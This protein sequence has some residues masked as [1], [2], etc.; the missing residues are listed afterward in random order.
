MD[1]LGSLI[2][3]ALLIGFIVLTVRGHIK[4]AASL[5]LAGLGFFLLT[6]GMI[7][8]F[9]VPNPSTESY[10]NAQFIPFAACLIV[11]VMF[12]LTIIR[13]VKGVQP[14]QHPSVFRW[15]FLVLGALLFFFGLSL[16][17]MGIYTHDVLGF[18]GINPMF[19][20]VAIIITSIVTSAFLFISSRT[21]SVKRPNLMRKLILI[22]TTIWFSYSALTIPMILIFAAPGEPRYSYPLSACIGSLAILP[23]AMLVFRLQRDF[24]V[25]KKTPPELITD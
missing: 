25:E 2:Y 12:L 1:A 21:N 4:I 11:G 23:F 8:I 6:V 3:L 19:S 5:S 10:K 9:A 14:L 7:V 16:S 18:D 15:I 20:A 17:L 22:I 24:Y 13:P